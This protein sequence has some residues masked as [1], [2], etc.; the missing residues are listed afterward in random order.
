MTGVM[1]ANWQKA[2]LVGG[3]EPFPWRTGILVDVFNMRTAL[4]DVY[5]LGSDDVSV[6]VSPPFTGP[7]GVG[8]AINVWTTVLEAYQQLE[9][10][11]GN[12]L[13][14]IAC[15][16][17]RYPTNPL[18]NNSCYVEELQLAEGTFL[19]GLYSWFIYQYHI[20]KRIVSISCRVLC[21]N[22]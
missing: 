15:H 11:G 19:R 16:G 9:I 2:V 6:L 5:G 10:G 21:T 17:N 14:Y 7:D 1:A 4:F 3:F 13:L 8:T 18:E 12:V 20:I 22:F